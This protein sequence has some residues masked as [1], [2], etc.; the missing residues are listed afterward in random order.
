MRRVALLAALLVSAAPV[1]AQTPPKAPV[2]TAVTKAADRDVARIRASAGFKA[3]LASLDAGHDAFV[4]EIVELTEIPAP[5]F[6]EA[7]RAKAVAEKFRAIG[8]KDVTIDAEG[9]VL[10]LRPGSDPALPM[11]AIAAHLDTVF[12][13]GTP[14]K[15][16]REGTKLFAPGVGDDTRGVAALLAYARALD[17]GKI[18]TRAPILFVADVGEEGRGDLRGV[19]YLFT[20]GAM[21]DRIGAFI[22]VD[23]GGDSRVTHAGV[24]SK[25]YHV[26][27]KGPG[28]HS[29]GAFGIVNPMAAMSS[30]VSELYKIELPASPRT[31]YAAS[32]TGGGTSVNAIP[33]EVFIDIDMRSE[34]AAALADLEKRFLGIVQASVAGENSARSTRFGAISADPQVIGDRPA[35]ATPDN[36]ALVQ[37]T[38]AAIRAFGLTPG[39][40][41]SSTDANLPMSLGIPAITVGSGGGGG[42]GHSLDEWIDVAKPESLRGLSVGLLTL[43][44]AAGAN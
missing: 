37:S 31:T 23:G 42:R 30:A 38:A 25:R 5:P 13:E 15:V 29:Y 43:I 39:F 3:A 6:K 40:G 21:K 36:A 8:L 10:G 18:T 41:A 12:P 11:V 7:V 35:G 22:S 27:F 17:A 19:R 9:N 2:A 16:R 44:A 24:G 1:A 34:S 28:G 32:V 33:D 4:E 26:V 14:I 20:K